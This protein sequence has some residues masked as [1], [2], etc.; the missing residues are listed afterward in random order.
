MAYGGGEPN[1]KGGMVG[2]VFV[3]LAE[4]VIVLFND[5][6][7]RQADAIHRRYFPELLD[8]RVITEKWLR[9]S[10]VLWGGI[11]ALMGLVVLGLY[12]VHLGQRPWALH[13]FG[14]GFALIWIYSFPPLKLNYRGFGEIL[15]GVGVG[16]LLPF[17]GFYLA[18]GKWQE[19]SFLYSVPI[20]LLALVS[21][22]AS[23]LK[24]E[25]GDRV[26][27]KKTWTVRYGARATRGLIL[28]L[29]LSAVIFCV[30]LSMVLGGSIWL[31]LFGVLGPLWGIHQGRF[32]HQQ[33]DFR[34]LILLKEY[35]KTLSRGYHLTCIGLILGFFTHNI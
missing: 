20:M 27:G 11:I 33:A 19:F 18:C 16:L 5:Y 34:N 35:K 13:L 22:L 9:P 21:A 17:T 24:H 25:P 14:T 30:V 10:S 2:I 7:D 1:W 28:G 6:A 31:Q 8:P 4:L 32:G 15:E 12:L 3:I 29:Q 23:G 26:S